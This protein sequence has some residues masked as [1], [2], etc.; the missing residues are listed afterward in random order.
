MQIFIETTGESRTVDFGG[1]YD[2]NATDSYRDT[3]VVAIS[4]IVREI[5]EGKPWKQA[6]FDEFGVGSWISDIITSDARHRFY[7]ESL[8]LC[9]QRVLD[10]GSGW[11]QIAAPLTKKNDL[12]CV[13]LSL[14]K[15]VFTQLISRVEGDSSRFCGIAADIGKIHFQEKFDTIILNGVLEWIPKFTFSSK[16]VPEAQYDLLRRAKQQLKPGGRIVIGIENRIGL[17]YLLGVPDDHIGRPNLLNLDWETVVKISED[18]NVEPPRVRT[19]T[20][21]EYEDLLKK[22]GFLPIEFYCAFPDYKIPERVI[23]V[24]DSEGL[25]NF[26]LNETVPNERSGYDG[27]SIDINRELKSHYRTFAR[28]GVLKYFSPSYYI[29]AFA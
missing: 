21:N 27:A 20:M 18:Q 22:V 9:D 1:V 29:V 5:R 2:F 25:T 19:M 16:T 23:S 24:N 28:M 7:T 15:L 3:G 17:K 8:S 26:A 14:D 12:F 4:R 11:G 10:I 6:V 13:D